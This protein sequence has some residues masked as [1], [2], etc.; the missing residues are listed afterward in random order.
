[1]KLSRLR[2]FKD[3][4]LIDEIMVE[5]CILKINKTGVSRYQFDSSELTHL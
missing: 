2:M 4:T 1:M 5:D 3:E